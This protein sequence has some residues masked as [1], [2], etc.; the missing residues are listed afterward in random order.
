METDHERLSKLYK[1]DPEAFEAERDRLIN[2]AIEAAPKEKKEN[3]RIFQQK[4]DKIMDAAGSK[5]LET[6]ELM[7]QCNIA[8]MARQLNGLKDI[9]GGLK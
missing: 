1:D 8:E 4:V 9:L 3:M 6:L 5:R 2:E 7:M